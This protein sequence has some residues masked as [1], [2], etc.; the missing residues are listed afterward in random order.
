MITTSLE[1]QLIRNSIFRV[2]EISIDDVV[3]EANVI[4]LEMYDIDMILDMDWSSTHHASI[5]CFTKKIVFRK[6]GY[7]KLE[8]DSDRR[9][10]PTCV[11]SALETKRLLHQRM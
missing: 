10:L 1:E 4:P 3:L 2:Y 8:F 9:I 6:L 5:D 7:P 11:I